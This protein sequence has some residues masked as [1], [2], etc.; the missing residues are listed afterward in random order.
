MRMRRFIKGVE[1]GNVLLAD[2]QLAT[3]TI[4]TLTSTTATL[5][6]ANINSETT[7][8]GTIH[9]FTVNS[10]TVNSGTAHLLNV[11]TQLRIPYNTANIATG[12]LY[13]SG[14][15]YMYV[16]FKTAWKSGLMG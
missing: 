2:L 9:R 6:T 13:M 15:G 3:G 1:K 11:T 12:S 16:R 8:T 10:G 14:N 7:K 5:A 4:T